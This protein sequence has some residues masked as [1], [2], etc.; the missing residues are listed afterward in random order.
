MVDKLELRKGDCGPDR[1]LL[2]DLN[3][4]P[5]VLPEPNA[6]ATSSGF[7]F[8][9]IAEANNFIYVYN[10]DGSVAACGE[11]GIGALKQ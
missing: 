10:P 4:V 7:S 8:E 6:S 2:L 1:E 9:E 11:V 5:S 3:A